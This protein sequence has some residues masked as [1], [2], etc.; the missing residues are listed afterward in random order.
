MQSTVAGA[1]IFSQKLNIRKDCLLELGIKLI[2]DPTIF[3]EYKLLSKC[4]KVVNCYQE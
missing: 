4:V 2:Y 1:A 3:Q